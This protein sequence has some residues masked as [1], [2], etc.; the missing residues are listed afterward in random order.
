MSKFKDNIK[1]P[2]EFYIKAPEALG[3]NVLVSKP[4][5]GLASAYPGSQIHVL[6]SQPLL[7]R[8]NP[9]IKE[10]FP[11]NY[12]ILPI[13][14][15]IDL[16]NYLTSEPAR[17]QDYSDPLHFTGIMCRIAGVEDDGLGPR[18]Y[19]SEEELEQSASRL[20]RTLLESK[21]DPEKPVITMQ[22][23]T[24]T[25]FKNWP[26]NYW[27]ELASQLK[28]DYTL[29]QLVWNSDTIYD[30]PPYGEKEDIV[31]IRG[32]SVR[33]IPGVI[34]ASEGFVCLDTFTLHATK[35]V[36]MENA[37]VILGARHPSEVSYHQFRNYSIETAILEGATSHDLP[38]E[39]VYSK[40]LLAL[41]DNKGNRVGINEFFNDFLGTSK[42]PDPLQMKEILPEMVIQGIR[43]TTPNQRKS[44]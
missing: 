3:D 19:L 6:T 12:M 35:A 23:M 38:N 11:S 44:R 33:E 24:S 29:V 31:V 10:T 9:H 8:G 7:F 30:E 20:E 34:K 17:N 2:R 15:F 37:H 32:L 16:S 27:R 1:M 41:Y 13:E 21:V 22:T 40:L 42:I 36:G 43:E 4:V 39:W 14:G 26:D 28:K 18:L 5:E 25:P